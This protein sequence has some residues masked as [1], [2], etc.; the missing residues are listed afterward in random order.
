MVAQLL[1]VSRAGVCLSYGSIAKRTPITRHSGSAL[2]PLNRHINAHYQVSPHRSVQTAPD[3]LIQPTADWKPQD[4]TVSLLLSDS[5]S[6]VACLNDCRPVALSPMVSKRLE[7]LVKDLIWDLSLPTLHPNQFN[8]RQNR[9]KDDTL[10]TPPST[11]SGRGTPPPLRSAKQCHSLKAQASRLRQGFF[12][13]A[14]RLRQ[15]FFH[16]A[17]RLRQGFFHQA[18]RLQQGF[19]HQATRLRQGFFHQATRLTAIGLWR[20]AP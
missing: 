12:H 16:Q 17:T 15:G 6:K 4:R 19:F 11:T 18:T 8:Y 20:S 5:K 14:T 9:S 2:D 13:Q 3:E 1:H 10:T 7:D